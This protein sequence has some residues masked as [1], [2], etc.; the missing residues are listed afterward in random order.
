[1]SRLLTLR[2]FAY[3][4]AADAAEIRVLAYG[5][6]RSVRCA[7]EIRPATG[8]SPASRRHSEFALERF[9]KCRLRFVTDLRRNCGE[10]LASNRK[11]LC[12]NLQAPLRQ[13]LYGGCPSRSVNRCASAERDN[14]TFRASSSTVH[15]CAGCACS[16][17]SA[18]PT[19]RSPAPASHPFRSAGNASMQRRT[20]STKSSSES[21]AR[22]IVL[23]ARDCA[24]SAAANCM[25]DSS[26]AEPGS[27][28]ISTLK[29]RGSSESI[30]LRNT[31]SQ[32][33]KPHSMRVTAPPPP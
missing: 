9:T 18:R 25:E 5:S 24:A 17:E 12:R 7:R 6:L 3:A 23:P 22:T 8:L 31:P 33:K 30:G 20:A 4:G 29:M 2:W 26:Q 14:P 1:M 27:L 19:N 15:A 13:V 11:L 10:R 32:A 16:V 21:L 28:R